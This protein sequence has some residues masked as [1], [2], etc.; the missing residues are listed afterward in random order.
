MGMCRAAGNEQRAAPGQAS[1]ICKELTALTGG[2]A[3]HLPQ[4]VLQQVQQASAVAMQL[5]QRQ[6]ALK[7]QD[8]LIAGR[9]QIG[10]VHSAQHGQWQHPA[11]V[12][13]GVVRRHPRSRAFPEGFLRSGLPSQPA[14]AG[15]QV[16]QASR[17][18]LSCGLAGGCICQTVMPVAAYAP[19]AGPHT[20]KRE[21]HSRGTRSAVA[22]SAISVAVRR[23]GTSSRAETSR[24]AALAQE[25]ACVHSKFDIDMQ[26]ARCMTDSHTQ[27]PRSDPARARHV[28]TYAGQQ[29]W[30]ETAAQHSASSAHGRHAAMNGLA[31]LLASWSSRLPG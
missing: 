15:M 6:R 5:C 27:A 31:R 24:Q 20:L 23:C 9:A 19:P 4:R 7:A 18:Q 2:A 21:N 13:G 1:D 26:L 16:Q 14:H 17:E 29:L 11:R 12:M 28:H 8:V 3:T 25:Y 22:A 30:I 10:A